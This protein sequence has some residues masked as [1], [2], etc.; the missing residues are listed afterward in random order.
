M[1]RFPSLAAARLG[2]VAANG[3]AIALIGLAAHSWPV[4]ERV[5]ALVV[6]RAS[7]IAGFPISIGRLHY[8]LLTLVF[9]ADDV[10]VSGVATG[11][12]RSVLLDVSWRAVIGGRFELEEVRVSDLDLR[13]SSAE[14]GVGV[15]VKRLS[16]YLDDTSERRLAGHASVGG[17]ASIHIGSIE[18]PLTR[19]AGELAF[20]GRTL[21]VSRVH[22]SAPG[23]D[24]AI[25][26]SVD[27]LLGHAPRLLMKGRWQARASDLCAVLVSH[28]ASCGHVRGGMLQGSLTVGGALASP[29]VHVEGL[30]TG[31]VAGVSVPA[32]IAVDGKAIVS[33]RAIEIPH[34]DVAAFGG[35][36]SLRGSMLIG[37]ASRI[38]GATL[39]WQG[40][41]LAALLE[42]VGHRV[43]LAASS[44]GRATLMGDLLTP[45]ALT[46]EAR[47]WLEPS[48]GTGV[49]VAGSVDARLDSGGWSVRLAESWLGDT[50]TRGEA[51]GRI[52][53][54]ASV[55]WGA[56]TLAGTMRLETA[57]VSRTWN[58][59]REVGIPSI[60]RVPAGGWHAQAVADLSVEG[61]LG[62]PVVAGIIDVTG[63]RPH[64]P[65]AVAALAHVRVDSSGVEIRSLEAR[66][67]AD[68]L[69][70]SGRY[71]SET[72]G[73]DGEFTATIADLG[74]VPDLFGV[75]GWHVRGR[76]DLAAQIAGTTSQPQVHG[77]LHADN[78][79]VS[80]TPRPEGGD[81]MT[82][83]LGDVAAIVTAADRIE[84]RMDVPDRRASLSGVVGLEAGWP[85]D[86]VVTL[87][88]I[89]VGDLL[90][91]A[92]GASGVAGRLAGTVSV[93]GSVSR[94]DDVRADVQLSAADATVHGINATLARPAHVRLESW[95]VAEILLDAR[96][97]DL[98]V[99]VQRMNANDPLHLSIEGALPSTLSGAAGTVAIDVDAVV[100]PSSID[101]SK[102]S[103]RLGD[104]S[105]DA[106]GQFPR[107]FV[108]RWLPEVMRIAA[109]DGD[110]RGSPAVMRV[111][112]RS[113]PLALIVSRLL[114]EGGD[115]LEGAFD[116]AAVMEADHPSLDGVRIDGRIERGWVQRDGIRFDQDDSAVMVLR[117]GVAS[118]TGWR[119]TAPGLNL[120]LSGESAIDAPARRFAL[121]VA[122]D[123]DLAAAFT[124]QGSR[125]GGLA[126]V[127]LTASGDR[128]GV[129]WNGQLDLRDGALVMRQRAIALTDVET[130]V[131]CVVDRCRVEHFTGRLNGGT[132]AIEGD[133]PMP[134]VAAE[135]R[136]R[137]TVRDAGL[138]MPKGTRHDVDADLDLIGSN[139]P[140][141]AGSVT[142]W[143]GAVSDSIASLTAL[144]SSGDD[145]V[146]IEQPRNPVSAALSRVGVDVRIVSGDDVTFDSADVQITATAD[147][148]V[149]GT[150]ASPQL[151]GQVATRER[152][153]VFLAGRSWDVEEGTIS[154]LEGTRGMD[155]R[156]A[157]TVTAPISK[158]VVRIRLSGP[159]SSPNLVM[160]S[161][162]PLGQSDLAELVLTGT[163]S[164]SLTRTSGQQV[165]TLVSSELLT[166]VGRT[167]GFDAV[168]IEH[169]QSDLS[170]TDIE[171]VSRLTVSKR[172]TDKFEIVYSQGL[173]ESDDLAW[174]LVL[175]PGWRSLDMRATI[176]T[177]GAEAYE[178]RQ[179]LEFGA[180][181]SRTGVTRSRRPTPPPVSRID[182]AGLAADEA[183]AVRRV[184]ALGVG[185]P[186]TTR[187]WQRDREAVARHF[188]ERDHL[189][190]RVR[191]SHATAADGSY[192]LTYDIAPGPVTRLEVRGDEV[193]RDT[194]AALRDAWAQTVIEDLVAEELADI[195]RAR[196]A[197]RGYFGAEVATTFSPLEDG[198]RLA[199][200]E[201]VRGQRTRHRSIEFAGNMAIATDDLRRAVPEQSPGSRYW[202]EPSL[203]E[204]PIAALVHN[205]GYLGARVEAMRTITEDRAT[206]TVHVD[207]GRAFTVG[208]LSIS[209]TAL[210][211]EPA[212]REGFGLA[213]GAPFSNQALASALASLRTAYLRAG[214]LE[215]E[216]ESSEMIRQDLGIVDVSLLVK[217]GRSS[218]LREIRVAGREETSAKLVARALGITAGGTVDPIALDQGQQRLYDTGIFRTVDIAVRQQD[219]AAHSV[220]AVV[221]LEE[222]ARYRLRYGVQF[223]PTTIE[224]ITTESNSAEPGATIDLQRRNLFGLGIVLGGGGVWSAEQYRVR[225]TASAAT[226]LGRPVSTTLTLEHAN[227]DRV[228]DDGLQVIDR[229]AAA[230]LEQRWRFGRERRIEIAY[231]F[232]LDNRRVEL[233]ATTA[234]AL[235]LRGRFAGLNTTFTYDTRDNRLNPRRGMF[236]SSRIEGSA[237]LWLSDV[238]FG[239]YQVQQYTFFPVGRL[240]LASGVRFGSLDVDNEKEPAAMLLYFK[241]GGG[242]SVRGYESDTLTPAYALG[243][244]VGGKVLLVLNEEVRVPLT[245]RFGIVGFFDAGNTFTGLDTINFSGLKVG[246]GS[247]VRVDTPVAVFRFDVGMPLPRPADSPRAR[248]YVSIG[249]AF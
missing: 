9:E 238:A 158:Y 93:A 197:A 5:R 248:W 133:V 129:S 113:L 74:A 211:G 33:A 239:R 118:L 87:D 144:V 186:F 134:G 94:P 3:L 136:L 169:S 57:D 90:G 35:T 145:G 194:V 22:V 141:L 220:D 241:T 52:P 126:H 85:F 191:A 187:Q 109:P 36:V 42:T 221:T 66:R 184:L 225:T 167:I 139:P 227:Q 31:L 214:Y 128:D 27:D 37:Q 242:S 151:R 60:P 54:H 247:G 108:N 142:L 149:G 26:G 38:T 13:A 56:V 2:R 14:R 155:A 243:M 21:E 19:V 103:A 185:K 193:G 166:S 20:H 217:E 105:A 59:L 97:D 223:G 34:L 234:E 99:Q 164:G 10:A 6:E 135:R 89:D 132:L 228:S 196:M 23:L 28:A 143:P 102:A 173:S 67:D 64:D 18:R 205:R 153:R 50:L 154:L 114:P 212:A 192:A 100:G 137:A 159:A 65:H 55:R 195:V 165:A 140:R 161:D 46:V 73:I 198:G 202:L 249:Q 12:A 1:S 218:V 45:E 148:R 39:T 231:G 106:T 116:I 30:T 62:D 41:D 80:R 72:A 104:A 146:A 123:I 63:S 32:A 47:T 48:R 44:G 180:P 224:S 175:K 92:A 110:E 210:L 163:T 178:L 219:G 78:L 162:P 201:I 176:R 82:V 237:G 86:V 84:L 206:V 25:D 200:I 152:G 215:A 226:F 204:P 171:P 203:L 121:A 96:I 120:T 188:H 111:E 209:G 130:S 69:K 29:V 83:A 181:R 95:H 172:L 53:G 207:E 77:V 24:V 189:R 81:S 124:L 122:G 240:T 115:G 157:A 236:H 199:T 177:N 174:I 208:A 182:V 229:T 127:D 119:W 88:G 58:T 168:R 17:P 43:P 7:E 147:L 107:R 15:D 183:M 75:S 222:R 71:A 216:V 11:F 230:V 49:P 125:V 138:E 170:T 213:P 117:N 51:S 101:I 98:A 246:V 235:P 91:S 232:N 190:V 76:G 68:L 61:T 40:I 233:T 112:L 131:A 245:R 16:L 244:P 4:R 160:T 8:N 79:E 179:E 70:G 156:I 150:L